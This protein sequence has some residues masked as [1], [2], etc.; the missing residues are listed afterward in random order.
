MKKL[1]GLSGFTLVEVI[2]VLVILAVLAAILIPS[3]TGYIAEANKKAAIAEARN[4]LIAA[5]TSVSITYA[6]MPAAL[7]YEVSQNLSNLTIKLN[8]NTGPNSS[9]HGITAAKQIYNYIEK[10]S[11]RKFGTLNAAKTGEII[12][13][14]INGAFK[15][16]EIYYYDGNYTVYMCSDADLTPPNGKKFNPAFEPTPTLNSWTIAIGQHISRIFINIR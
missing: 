1:K 8:S 13:K 10:Y 2:V 16:S 15:V 7:I 6:E 14:D 9:G 5:Q 11:E 4:V 3:L 12:I